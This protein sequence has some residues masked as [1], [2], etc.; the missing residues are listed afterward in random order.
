MKKIIS[1]INVPREYK[2]SREMRNR[3]SSS[4]RF[5]TDINLGGLRWLDQ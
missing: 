3:S 1:D 5:D 4:D 2:C